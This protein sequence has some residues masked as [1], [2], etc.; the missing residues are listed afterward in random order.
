MQLNAALGGARRI[1]PHDRV[2]PGGGAGRVVQRREH[3][4]PH[5]DGQIE[6]GR[7]LGDVVGEDQLGIDAQVL[8]HLGA[9]AHGPDG[10][11]GVGQRQMAALG[12]LQVEVQLVAQPAPEIQRLGV[13]LHTLRGEVVGPHDGGVASRVAA[14]E[15]ALVEHGNVGDPVVRGQVVRRGKPVTAAADDHGVV[16]GPQLR[17]R[18]QETVRR[19][20]RSQSVFQQAK[21]HG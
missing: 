12:V 18:R 3:R 8:V 2:V 15:I 10:G 1:G 7:Q 4:V 17:A 20:A 16:G 6:A 11:I 5:V 21:R 14:A 19:A 13:E 9:P